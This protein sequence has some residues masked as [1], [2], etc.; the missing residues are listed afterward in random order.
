[1]TS[2]V[3]PTIERSDVA[4]RVAHF[5]AEINHAVPT[6]VG[7]QHALKRDDQRAKKRETVWL[8]QRLA[9]LRC[10]GKREGGNR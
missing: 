10:A 8:R 5:L 9:S 4:L 1:M 7:V 6:V 3:P 2:N